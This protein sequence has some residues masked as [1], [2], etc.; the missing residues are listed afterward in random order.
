V[1]GT[2]HS[3]YPWLVAAPVVGLAAYTASHLILARSGRWAS[4]YPSLIFGFVPG[5]AVTAALSAWA[6]WNM[7][8][9][10][11]DVVGYGLLNG[12]TY[13]ALG[14]G[15]FHFV[16]M[17]IAS[18]RIRMLRELVDA[19]GRLDREHLLAGYNTSA[20]VELRITRLTSGGH[21]VVRDGRYFRGK[22]KFLLAAR[23]FDLLRR[24]LF[25]S[26]YLA[27]SSDRSTSSANPSSVERHE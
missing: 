1:T 18:L 21:F 23:C 27:L 12:A 15:Y 5:L 13:A 24:V 4:P 6:L 7:A 20:V 17:G 3:A 26:A 14:W 25:G 10:W 11:A 2:A 19:G 22:L 9:G 16:N 8:A